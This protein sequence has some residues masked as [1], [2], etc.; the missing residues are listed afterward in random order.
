V[1]KEVAEGKKIAHRSKAFPLLVCNSNQKRTLPGKVSF[2]SSFVTQGILRNGQPA[3]HVRTVT[4][5]TRRF[6]RSCAQLT[7]QQ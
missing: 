1:Q 3:N 7:P 2:F 4:S 6:N 5:S